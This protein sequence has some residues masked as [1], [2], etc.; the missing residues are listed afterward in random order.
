MALY[1]CF[2]SDMAHFIETMLDDMDWM[3]DVDVVELPIPGTGT[4][5]DPYDLTMEIP[6]ATR[7]FDNTVIVDEIENGGLFHQHN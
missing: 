7:L 5:N 6:V 3:V 1:S 2:D 4:L